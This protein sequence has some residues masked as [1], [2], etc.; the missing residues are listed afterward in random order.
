MSMSQDRDNPFAPPKAAVLQAASAD[1]GLFVEE[2]Q[3]VAAGRGG[4]WWAQA[5]ELF[6][7]APG[8]WILIFI[9]FMAVSLVFA[10]IPLGSLVTSVAY[11]VVAA[12]LMLGCRELEQGGTLRVIENE[13][14]LLKRLRGRTRLEL[15][16]RDDPLMRLDEF[17]LLSGPAENDVTEKYAA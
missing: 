4:T 2:G 9:V 10:I 3:R 14:G 15:D 17:R 16:M 8:T 13:P 12:G 1:D 7:Q 11:P 5:W 6:K